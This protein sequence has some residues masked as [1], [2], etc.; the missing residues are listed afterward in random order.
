MFLGNE[1]GYKKIG[2]QFPKKM[3]KKMATAKKQVKNV[4]NVGRKGKDGKEA[5]VVS[6]V[7][8]ILLL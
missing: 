4:S 3:A 7:C 1:I 6:A 2:E 5:D 8:S